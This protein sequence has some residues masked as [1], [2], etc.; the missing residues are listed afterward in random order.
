MIHGAP[1]A[2]ARRDPTLSTPFET[3]FAALLVLV[4]ACAIIRPSGWP[5]AVV[6]VQAAALLSATGAIFLDHARAKR[7]PRFCRREQQIRGFE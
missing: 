4:L 7:S 3:L 5:E 2:A 6:A 1:S